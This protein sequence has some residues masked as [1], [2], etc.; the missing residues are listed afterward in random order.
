MI[1]DPIVI[2]KS[3]G[4][5]IVSSSIP[6][7]PIQ[8]VRQLSPTELEVHLKNGHKYVEEVEAGDVQDTILEMMGYKK[9]VLEFGFHTWPDSNN[10]LLEF[11]SGQFLNL[12]AENF[13]DSIFSKTPYLNSKFV[14][15]DEIEVS[16]EADKKYYDCTYNSYDVNV[17][18]TLRCRVDFVKQVE[19][20]VYE[21]RRDLYRCFILGA[22]RA[23][24]NEF[25]VNMFE[26]DE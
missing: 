17:Y 11:A 20:F 13:V 10:G 12:A 1:D 3:K 4:N 14:S 24:A 9:F 23:P 15:V 7:D 18:I 26:E 5:F 8:L 22:N 21:N 2:R 6:T 19:N 16:E 25:E